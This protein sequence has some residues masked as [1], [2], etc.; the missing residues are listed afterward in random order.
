[1]YLLL[2]GFVTFYTYNIRIVTDMGWYMNSALNI[3]L[4]KGYIDMDGSL[5]FIRGPIFPLMITA[6]YWLLGVSPW[7]A[8]WVVRV[9]AI[10]NPVLIYFFGKKLFNKWVGFL[11]ALLILSSYS[12]NFWSYRHLDAVWPFFTISSVLTIYVALE[13]RRYAYFIAAGLLMGL[14]YLVKQAPILLFPL[15]FI[16]IIIVKDYRQKKNL[17]GSLIFLL[18]TA[19]LIFPWVHYVYF[20]TQNLKLALLGQG[21]VKASDA[22]LKPDLVLFIRRYFEGLWLYYQG[23]GNS[24]SQHFTLAPLFALAWAYTIFRALKKEKSSILLLICLLLISPYISIAGSKNLRLGQLI[25]FLFLTYLVTARFCFEMSKI[26]IDKVK[27]NSLNNEKPSLYASSLF[28]LSLIAI[29]TFLPFRNDKGNIVFLERSHFYQRFIKS[30]RSYIIKGKYNNIGKAWGKWIEKDI[31]YASRIMVSLP[32]DGKPLYFY[33]LGKHRIFDMP[34]QYTDKNK[35]SAWK[36]EDNN[37]IFLSSRGR[38]DDWKN[39]LIA[40]REKDLL[41]SI[42]E[43]KIEYILVG[44][45]R[46]YLTLYF[47]N[48]ENFRL[49][50]T[51]GNGELKIYKPILLKPASSFKTLISTNAVYYLKEL[52][53][54][55]TVSLKRYAVNFLK[56]FLGLDKDSVKTI[57]A[58]ENG[59]T[60]EN[61]TVVQNG[62][63]YK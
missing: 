23:V 13:N 25:L 24:L 2:L 35:K 3:F 11:A 61:Y 31:A 5:I 36:D 30:N 15:S 1:M 12:I 63:I 59:K 53:K 19:A 28:I 43:K 32:S 37:V 42:E 38:Y 56:P 39:Y 52:S 4:G 44:K 48:N 17:L 50:K 9:F 21:G 29:Q 16:L 41:S 45:R 27:K 33:S 54:K 47:N 40:L 62:K 55:N 8:F 34:I 60:Y 7:S 18:T 6:C 58:L 22:V 20:E 10:L 14:G 51:F 46:N 57:A 26:V 49:V